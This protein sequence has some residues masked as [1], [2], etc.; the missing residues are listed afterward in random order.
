AL[1]WVGMGQ[2]RGWSPRTLGSALEARRVAMRYVDRLSDREA[3]VLRAWVHY[4]QREPAGITLLE[5]FVRRHP[6][7][8]EAWVVLSEFPMHRRGATPAP[9]DSVYALARKAAELEPG[10]APHYLHLVPLAAGL[11]DSIAAGEW[12]AAYSAAGGAESDNIAAGWDQLD[13]YFGAN[14]TQEEIAAAART[15]VQPMGAVIP[16]DRLGRLLPIMRALERA[17]ANS[18]VGSRTALVGGYAT[19]ALNAGALRE[20]EAFVTDAVPGWSPTARVAL[21]ILGQRA[22]GRDSDDS[23]HEAV[24]ALDCNSDIACVDLEV[25][26]VQHAALAEHDGEAEQA[27]DELDRLLASA[28]SSGSP[29]TVR[30]ADKATGAR[31]IWLLA[32]GDPDG[33]HA[34][35]ESLRGQRDFRPFEAALAAD[36]AG[37]IERAEWLYRVASDWGVEKAFAA[38]LLADFYERRGRPTEALREYRRLLLMWEFA[39]AD[40]PQLA[41]AQAALARL[42][43]AAS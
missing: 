19:T 35:W 42:E 21:R 11:N 2:V 34:L 20:F 41:E 31:A 5:D 12:A 32:S 8:A 1:A 22:Y 37:Q 6:D 17:T 36:G 30:L 29:D 39:D 16:A 40:L 4:G 23:I 25:L 18:S 43:A 9:R 13:L 14:R 33:A 38:R 7:V 24:A 3:T 27:F 26:R 28:R 10:F 15:D